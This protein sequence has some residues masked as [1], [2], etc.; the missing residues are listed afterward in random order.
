MRL[1][2]GAGDSVYAHACITQ[3]PCKG[4]TSVYLSRVKSGFGPIRRKRGKK[5]LEKKVQSKALGCLEMVSMLSFVGSG[6][7]ATSGNALVP[8]E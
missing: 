3:M 2:L 6:L 5:N 1:A 7:E 8:L 4:G